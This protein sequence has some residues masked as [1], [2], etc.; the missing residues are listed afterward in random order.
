[1][2]VSPIGGLAMAAGIFGLMLLGATTVGRMTVEGVP[3]G[4]VVPVR[5]SAVNAGI[6]R[7]HF[8]LVDGSARR[9]WLV[10]DFNGWARS[11]TPLERDASGDAWAV[12]VNVP[13]GRHEYAFIVD[14]GQG[15]KW[16]ADPGKPVMTDEFGTESSVLHVGLSDE[17]SEAAI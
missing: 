17:S 15:E 13:R 14:D 3:S 2:H 9:V 1:M 7:V 12:S 8:V 11:G 10:G 5:T 6:E 16:I 4:K